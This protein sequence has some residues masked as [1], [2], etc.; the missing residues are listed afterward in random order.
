M[1]NFELIDSY[2]GEN[3]MC[4]DTYLVMGKNVLGMRNKEIATHLKTIYGISGE[5]KVQRRSSRVFVVVE[6]QRKAVGA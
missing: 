2:C 6:Y 5:Y 4:Q 3:G 1:I